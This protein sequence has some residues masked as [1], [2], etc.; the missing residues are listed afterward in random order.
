MFF[1]S[2]TDPNTLRLSGS[3]PCKLDSDYCKYYT[4]RM[5]TPLDPY[6]TAELD[7]PGLVD[8]A[9]RVAREHDRLRRVHRHR[10]DL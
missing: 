9:Q 2:N 7:L 8:A 1:P 3:N 5:S 4:D 6:R 10:Q